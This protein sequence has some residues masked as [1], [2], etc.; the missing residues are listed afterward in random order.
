MGGSGLTTLTAGEPA[1]VAPDGVEGRNFDLNDLAL[2][3]AGQ[4]ERWANDLRRRSIKRCPTFRIDG[5]DLEAEVDAFA[6]RNLEHLRTPSVYLLECEGADKA[7]LAWDTYEEAK[8]LASD[9]ALSPRNAYRPGSTCIYVGKSA[10]GRVPS[11]LRAHLGLRSGSTG[12]LH[13]SHWM[14]RECFPILV[15]VA[16]CQGACPSMIE[17]MEKVLWDQFKPLFGRGGSE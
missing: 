3:A 14:P 2:S 9:R 4:L 5:I 6:M 11:R 13:L 16:C 7:A 15:T 17:A 1:S 8:T 10:K 12:A